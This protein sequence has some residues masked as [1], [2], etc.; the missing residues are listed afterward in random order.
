MPTTVNLQGPFFNGALPLFI[1]FILLIMPLILKRI[2]KKRK[3]KEEKK[4]KMQVNMKPVPLSVKEK[5]AKRLSD[6]RDDY[7][8]GRRDSRDCY[9]LLSFII[10][11]FVNEYIGIDVTKM[12]L[13]EI[14][15]VKIK[16]LEKLIEEYYACEFAPDKEGDIEAAIKNTIRAI[17]EWK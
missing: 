1:F 5:Y 12:T 11:E 3:L 8:G 7:T 9:Q 10:R 17:E 4:K 15:G 16:R 2:E 6:I 14:R 13:A